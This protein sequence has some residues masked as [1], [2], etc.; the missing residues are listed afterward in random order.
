MEEFMTPEKIDL[1]LKACIPSKGM[2][3]YL[4]TQELSGTPS[5]ISSPAH[6]FL[7]KQKHN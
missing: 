4:M 7:L 3:D 1:L 5:P 2:R 6:Q